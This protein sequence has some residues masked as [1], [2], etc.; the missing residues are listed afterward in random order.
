MD[1][2]NIIAAIADEHERVFLLTAEDLVREFNQYTDSFEG[3]FYFMHK[4]PIWR[5]PNSHLK[6]F[7][8]APNTGE[9]IDWKRVYEMYKL[10]LNGYSV[11]LEMKFL[12][13]H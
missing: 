5:K 11:E 7:D 8:F 3:F 1:R 2:N 12:T 10:N 4:K 6:R 13:E 9:K